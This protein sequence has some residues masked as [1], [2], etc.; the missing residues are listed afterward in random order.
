MQATKIEVRTIEPEAI[1][2]KVFNFER[3][4]K[5]Y[6]LV[7]DFAE[8]K[9]ISDWQARFTLQQMTGRQKWQA[10]HQIADYKEA[11]RG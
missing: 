4:P 8:M 1:K 5:T 7:E 9:G 3:T 6:Q 2:I 10:A 11:M